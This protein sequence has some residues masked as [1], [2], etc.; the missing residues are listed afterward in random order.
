MRFD[1]KAI[2][3]DIKKRGYLYD[4]LNN[5]WEPPGSHRFKELTLIDTNVCTKKDNASTGLKMRRNKTGWIDDTLNIKNKSL[6][7]DDFIRLVNVDTGLSV[8]PEFYFLID[9]QYRFDY[10]IPL[11]TDGR[12][13]KIAIECDG[14]IHARGN[15]G[16]SSPTGIA[17]DMD[18]GTLAA[19]N[20]WTLIRRTPANLYTN[21][22]IILINKAIETISRMK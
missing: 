6:Y 12:I 2:I 4:A 15:S 17:R 16:H 21:D 14:G 20:G 1:G 7:L 9:K 13:L 8:W 19:V 5:C 10:A 11:H 18:K 22:T 3:A